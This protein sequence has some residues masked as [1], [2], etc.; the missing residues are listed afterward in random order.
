MNDV[1]GV[2]PGRVV[3]FG[4]FDAVMGTEEVVVVAETEAQ[5]PQ[6]RLEIANQICYQVNRS[7]DI[8]LRKAILVDRGWLLKTS[9]GKIA[10]SANREKYLREFQ[11]MAPF[12][13]NTER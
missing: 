2:Y 7:S 9:S 13:A 12:S 1:E 5:D 3:A 6:R 8:V 10:R 4:V 11:N